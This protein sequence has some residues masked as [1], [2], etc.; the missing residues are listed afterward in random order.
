[1][2]SVLFEEIG[3]EDL[4]GIVRVMLNPL[5]MNTKVKCISLKQLVNLAN[6]FIHFIIRFAKQ[7]SISLNEPLMNYLF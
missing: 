2:G 1:M 5:R 6:I 7:Q 4:E 3:K